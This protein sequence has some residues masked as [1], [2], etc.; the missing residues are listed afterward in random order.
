MTNQQTAANNK[1]FSLQ[2]NL[3]LQ[4]G[5]FTL[6]TGE[7]NLAMQG[8]TVLF[9]RSGS[10]KS[11]LLRAISGLE[12][13]VK[14]QL[15]FSQT[16]WLNE[17]TSL[18]T[19]HRH[20]GFVFQDAALFPHMTVYQN[21]MYGVKRLPKTVEV[22]DFDEIVERLA[23]ADKLERDVLSLSGGERQR[24][25]IAR[26]LLL[27]PQ[28]LCM[29]EPLSALDW[30]A[31]SEIIKLIDEVA[32]FYQIPVI[33]ITHSPAEVERLADQI[34]FIES[35]RIERVESLQQALARPDSPLFDD[36]GAVSVLQ[37]QP[38]SVMDGLRPI[39]MGS[40]RLWLSDTSE[41]HKENVRVR[42]LAKDV[43]LALSDP[44]QLSIMN[45]LPATVIELIPE[46]NHRMLVRLQLADQQML[47][48]EITQH[49][50]KR[51]QLNV[52]MQLFALIKSVALAE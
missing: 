9:G 5:G 42:V 22:A 16:V 26:A 41:I 30:R 50:A 11:T 39:Q 49:S 52:G 35:G 13:T 45:H 10:G 23:I 4:K 15:S 38:L 40:Y 18:D 14:G 31:K 32:E 51:L 36:E 8:V 12:P 43:S 20:I 21:L 27:K 7:F 34:V 25:A 19:Q 17:N 46:D 48:A 1:T 33:Y 47:F 24:V 28:L 37:G 29:D 6:Q 2:G 44:Q 3:T